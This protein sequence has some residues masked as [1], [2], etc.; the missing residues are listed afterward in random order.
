MHVSTFASI[1]VPTCNRPAALA[2]CIDHLR[3]SIRATG[4]TDIEIVVTDDGATPAESVLCARFPEVRWHRGPRRGPAANRNSGVTAAAG[5]WILFT[6]DDCLPSAA[7]VG[8]L[9][10]AIAAHPDVTVFEGATTIDRPIARLDEEAPWNE[11]GGYLWACN[12]AI[13]RALFLE[14]GG[15]CELFPAA[16]SE[17]ADFKLRVD[18][19]GRRIVFVP[20]A[21]VCHPVRATRGLRHQF[22]IGRSYL[23]LARRH[24]E[25]LGRA[26]WRDV[27]L[28][29]VRMVVAAVR[30]GARL[31]FRG[32]GYEF[33]RIAI[34]SGFNVVAIL[35]RG[36]SA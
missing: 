1:V 21:V 31:R 34:H 29:A 5:R 17:D 32:V 7:W 23:L 18:K 28:N 2:E 27:V 19:S 20:S 35:R 25:V 26:P 10:H 11:G 15:F 9:L 36:S 30:R 13:E 16:A 22:K 12:M 14:L 3:R 4:R 33:G 8:A 6:D 24:P